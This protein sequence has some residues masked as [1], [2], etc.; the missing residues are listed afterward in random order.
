[1][2]EDIV[3]SPACVCHRMCAHNTSGLQPTSSSACVLIILNPSSIP[4]KQITRVCAC[5]CVYAAPRPQKEVRWNVYYAP[6]HTSKV[7]IKPGFDC[8]VTAGRLQRQALPVEDFC[9]ALVLKR[10]HYFKHSIKLVFF[11]FCFAFG[12][13]RQNSASSASLTPQRL[14]VC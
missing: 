9:H 7:Q 8:G 5:A 1:M 11:V 6:E 14:R 12:S 4:F 2:S 13:I 10:R 3:I